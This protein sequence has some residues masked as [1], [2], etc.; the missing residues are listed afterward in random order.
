MTFDDTLNKHI[1]A[2]KSRDLAR[3][4]ETLLDDGRLSLI[5]LDGTLMTDFESIVA[6]HKD[7]FEDEDWKIYL[8]EV[9]RLETA[10]LCNVLFEV[11]YDDLDPDGFQYH[12]HYYL[13]LSFIKATKNG[14]NTSEEWLLAFDQ[15]TYISGNDD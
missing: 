11:D 5:L 6:F 13:N 8:R 4:T 12:L 7:W 1:S 14:A 9:Q 10:E 3:F 2:F 15:N